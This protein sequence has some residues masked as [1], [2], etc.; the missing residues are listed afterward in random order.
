MVYYMKSKKDES[1]SFEDNYRLL[2]QLATE[3]QDNKIS[4]DQLVPRVQAALEAFKTCRGI[5]KETESRLT[6]ISAEFTQ[7]NETADSSE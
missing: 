6:E 5:L 7:L 2:E 3:L 4:V 1:Q